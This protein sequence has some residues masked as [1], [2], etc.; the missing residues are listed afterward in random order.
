MCW[1]DRGRKLRCSGRRVRVMPDLTAAGNRPPLALWSAFVTNSALAFASAE[2]ITAALHEVGHGLCAQAFG[3]SPRVYAFYENNPSGDA[4]E[5]VAILA[6]GPMSSLILG[7]VF[8]TWYRR[9]KPRYSYGRLLLLWLSLVGVMEFVN[10]LIATPWLTAGDTARIADV[11]GLPAIARYGLSL[12][13]VASLVF[14]GRPA[15]DSMLALAPRSVAVGTSRARQRFFMTFVLPS[16]LAGVACTALAGIGSRPF[17]VA[18]G[19]V[20]TFATIDIVIAAR[21]ADGVPPGDG[22]R[23]N[24]APLRI[25]GSAVAIYAALAALYVFALSRGVPV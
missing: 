21:Y 24:D 3:F 14:F 17:Y 1:T 18:Y 12:I 20:G 15:A 19:L 13:G 7:M 11:F 10:Y 4:R 16:L 5:T 23:G 6:A 8:W 2:L 9:T 25:E 22:E